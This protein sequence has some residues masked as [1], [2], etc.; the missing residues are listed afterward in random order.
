MTIHIEPNE[1]RLAEKVAN[2]IGSRWSGVEVDDL[3]S[4]LYLWLVTNVKIVE[5]WRGE[6]GGEGKLYVSLRREAA[7]YS[8]KEQAARI[9]RPIQAGNYYNP[10]LVERALPFIFED[11]PQTTVAVNPV[12]GQ[13]AGVPAEFDTALTLL[14]D[15]KGAFYGLN[16]EVKQVLE[17][18]FR[19]GLNFE[20]IGELR[21][22]T[23]DGAR[24]QV[25]RAV[26]RL[27]DALAGERP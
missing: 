18:R 20:E 5:R 26:S 7:K 12:T 22:I 11:I 17:W 24:K 13:S 23:K 15:I 1:L 3:T 25:Q 9:G 16:R 27:V 21:Q 19:D 6:E 2:R 14:A 8:A 4:H 10:D